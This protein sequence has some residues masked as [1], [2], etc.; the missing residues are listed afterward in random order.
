LYWRILLAIVFAV[1]QRGIVVDTIF[2]KH[3]WLM[4]ALKCIEDMMHELSGWCCTV[5]LLRSFLIVCGS[6]PLVK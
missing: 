3:K 6:T 2:A 5:C 1:M 4:Y